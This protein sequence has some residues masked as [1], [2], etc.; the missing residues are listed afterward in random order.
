MSDFEKVVLY[1]IKRKTKL[2]LLS[3]EIAEQTPKISLV[4]K[5][6]AETSSANVNVI[7]FGLD[8]S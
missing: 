8:E 4:A 3:F 1:I 2:W 7:V 6:V 5:P